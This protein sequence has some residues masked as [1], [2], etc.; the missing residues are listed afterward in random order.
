M[1]PMTVLLCIG[2]IAVGVAAIVY[3]LLHG[4]KTPTTVG[5]EGEI[6][7][8]DMPEG[9]GNEESEAAVEN[10]ETAETSQNE[11]NTEE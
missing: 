7:L 3:I 6:S 4:P 11:E 2:V 8:G 9:E 10:T 1:E 5:R